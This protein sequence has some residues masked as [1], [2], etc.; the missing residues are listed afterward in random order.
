MVL[1]FSF[2]SAWAKSIALLMPVADKSGSLSV[3]FMVSFSACL[4]SHIVVLCAKALKLLSVR[5][6]KSKMTIVLWNM[7][8]SFI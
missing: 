7:Y 3:G 1:I 5:A 2:Y 8:L 6:V 4:T